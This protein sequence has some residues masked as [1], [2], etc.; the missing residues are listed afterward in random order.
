MT[1]RT[2]IWHAIDDYI[3]W[4]R[5]R[6]DLSLHEELGTATPNDWQRSDDTGC[7]GYDKMAEIVANLVGFDLEKAVTVEEL[8]VL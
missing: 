6:A 3:A 8:E 4:A 2:P 1:D 7:A 5:E